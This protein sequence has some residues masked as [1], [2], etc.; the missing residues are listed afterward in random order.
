MVK[1]LPASA[2]DTGLILESGR[3]PGEGKGNPFQ[4]SCLGNPMNREAWRATVHG[5]SELNMTKQLTLS[6]LKKSVNNE[7]V[8]NL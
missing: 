3:T 2:G 5:V 1:N 7:M 6:V 8:A 4:Y